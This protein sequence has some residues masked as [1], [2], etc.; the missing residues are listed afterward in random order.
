MRKRILCA[1]A[2]LTPMLA[3]AQ[4]RMFWTDEARWKQTD[5]LDFAFLDA[6]LAVRLLDGTI[7]YDGGCLFN[8]S[9][10]LVPPNDACPLGTTGFIA[11]G[12]VDRDGINDFGSFWSISSITPNA[13]VEPF[14]PELVRLLSGPP[15][16]IPEILR[17]NQGELS[18]VFTVV[19]G[20]VGAYYNML[21]PPASESVVTLYDLERTYGGGQS[22]LER[23]YYDV[24]WGVYTFSFPELGQPLAKYE[25][26]VDHLA[27]ADVYPSRAAIERGLRVVNENWRNGSLQFDPRLF[28]EFRWGGLTSSNTL[29]SDDLLFSLRGNQYVTTEVVPDPLDPTATTTIEVTRSEIPPDILV[30]SKVTGIACT[31]VT[32]DLDLT[33]VL[34]PGSRY[35]MEITSGDLAGT[36]VARQFPATISPTSPTTA[37][38]EIPDDLSNG[39]LTNTI[40]AVNGDEVTGIRDLAACLT[41]GMTYRM[42]VTSGALSGTTQFPV[43]DWGTAS[44]LPTD[45]DLRTV[46][47]L[48]AGLA[49][50]DT[51]Q[52]V[53][54]VVGQT[55]TITD[56]AGFY[57]ETDTDLTTIITGSAPR[58][59][60]YDMVFTSGDLQ[61]SREDI[62]GFRFPSDFY[63][64]TAAD[65]SSDL[66]VGDTFVID[67]PIDPPSLK[68]GDEFRILQPFSEWVQD[69]YD[70][71]EMIAVDAGT[72][73]A[74]YNID[75]FAGGTQTA[76]SSLAN[77]LE[78]AP[79]LYGVA[80]ENVIVF[81]PFPIQT[82]A[83]APDRQPFEVGLLDGGYNL[84]PLFFRPGDT[85][86]G[87]LDL[88]RSVESQFTIDQALRQLN[89]DVRFI[90]TYEGFALLGGFYGEGF[91][92][93]TPVAER[94]PDFDFDRDGVTNLMEYALGTDVADPGDV[95]SFEFLGNP[96][97]G[98]CT[99]TIEKRPFT[100]GS[101]SYFFE[102]SSNL[103]DWTTITPGDP[104][105]T[106]VEDSRERLTVSN[107]GMIP[108]PPPSACYLRVIVT[109]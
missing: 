92:F 23:Y 102:Y 79:G 84:G 1:L 36:A 9:L 63:L 30:E 104:Y 70:A 5:E 54:E 65:L 73:L 87:R 29:S 105:F 85:A 89:F 69:K 25:L 22:E 109:Q 108:D 10:V 13:F 66:E 57:I 68:L 28:S 7:F 31:T 11:Q 35:L 40:T 88:Q 77:A 3:P 43:T 97:P 53:P 58:I 47:D 14:R 15:G 51:Y 42:T 38:L 99:A 41:P 46:D 48:S 27:I 34:D 91:P 80:R 67:R 83:G 61:G 62:A 71:G 50:G 55:V 6:E 39:L 82:P 24:A 21:S 18:A 94:A 56:V 106:I 12:D 37:D 103:K 45:F 4:L 44:G 17:E 96:G 8:G 100:G 76:S 2:I 72:L 75:I 101:L 52:L 74:T 26:S 59:A 49:V 86:T 19:D 60:D 81:P 78:V 107:L 20:S 16:G 32:A 95:P 98:L 64:R 93:G 33:E 90:D